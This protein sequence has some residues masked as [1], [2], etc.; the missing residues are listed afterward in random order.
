MSHTHGIRDITVTKGPG[1]GGPAFVARIS[2]VSLPTSKQIRIDRLYGES[3]YKP[4]S[5]LLSLAFKKKGDLVTQIIKALE[6]LL[7]EPD[8]DDSS[9]DGDE[10]E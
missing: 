6:D 1:F 5:Q 4:D 9:G 10:S 8:P 3:V 2:P 7:P